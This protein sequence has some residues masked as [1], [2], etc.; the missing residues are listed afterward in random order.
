MSL[1]RSAQ[2]PA[3]R[4]DLKGWAEAIEGRHTGLLEP[5]KVIEIDPLRNEGLLRS[6]TA[7]R[8]GD[9]LFYYEILLKGTRSALVRRY[10]AKQ[11]GTRSR[12]QVAFTLTH[13]ALA[14]LAGELT[15]GN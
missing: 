10:Q 3:G 14:K 6:T 15:A 4:V 13:E 2:A 5:L 12:E 9:S 7:A 1:A 11:A 8:R